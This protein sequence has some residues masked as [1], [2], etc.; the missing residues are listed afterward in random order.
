MISI[1]IANSNCVVSLITHNNDHGDFTGYSFSFLTSF[2]CLHQLFVSIPMVKYDSIEFSWLL[3]VE[4]LNPHIR[5]LFDFNVG[6]MLNTTFTLC[7]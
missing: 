2:Y 1:L 3:S 5:Q 7:D 4:R 6:G